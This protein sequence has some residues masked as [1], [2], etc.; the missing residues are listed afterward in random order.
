MKRV[1]GF[2]NFLL[3]VSFSWLLTISHFAFADCSAEGAP[4]GASCSFEV[5]AE[6]LYECASGIC[7]NGV[8]AEQEPE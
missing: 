2:T 8:C 6:G 4:I 5:C 3:V 7:V 1:W